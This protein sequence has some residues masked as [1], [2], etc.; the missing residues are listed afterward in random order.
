MKILSFGLLG[1]LT[2]MLMAA[3]VVEK[4][5]GSG[6]ASALLYTSPLTVAMWAVTAVCSAGYIIKWRRRLTW[7]ALLLH[8]A[9]IVILAG[10]AVTHF[11]GQQGKITISAG[12][13]TDSFTLAD[14]T[15]KQ[16]P[17][18]LRLRS[19]RIEC[20]PG[21]PT[22][23]DYV[24]ELTVDNGSGEE[25]ATVSM[26]N[27]LDVRGYRFYETAMGTDHTVLSVSHDP[28]GIGLTY[29]GYF[30]LLFA[31]VSFFFSRKT[32][33]F[34]LVKALGCVVL[35]TAASQSAAAGTT[36]LPQT[37]QRGLAK[38]FGRM[39]V[40]HN[41]RVCPVS[42]LA[43]DFCIKITGS[44]SY[45]GLSAEQVL[46][47]WIFYYPDWKNEPMVK[48]KPSVARQLGKEGK[49]VALS[50]FYSIDGFRL[51]EASTDRNVRDAIEKTALISSV[52]TG[53]ALKI[54]P[55]RL[56][57]GSAEWYSWTDDLPDETDADDR[58]FIMGS[59]EYFA[60]EIAHGRNISADS[61]TKRISEYQL[62]VLGS[63][64]GEESTAYR[65]EMLYNKYGRTLPIA[66]AALTAGLVTFIIFCRRVSKGGVLPGRIRIVF[67]AVSVIIFLCLTA[68]ISLRGIIAGQIPLGNG[69]E[70]ML[71]MAWVALLA[72]I[73][74]GRRVGILQP[75]SLIT[76]GL[77]LTVAMLSEKNPQVSHLMPVLQ[78]PLL[79][80]HVM[81]VMLSYALL[82][83][84]ALNSIAAFIAGAE[85]EASRRLAVLSRVMLY[86]ALF[87]LAAGI[88]TGAVWANQSWGRYWG[89]DPKE[90]WAL[91]T[92]IIYALPMHT[93]SFPALARPKTVHVYF[94]AAF[95]SVLITYFGVN[96]F[97]SGLHS[98]A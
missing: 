27:V 71:A 39:L 88:F 7:Q 72:G 67:F 11:A 26:N 36:E 53:S 47:G 2:L 1:V 96:F 48:V 56:D 59:M 83:F 66:I 16:L 81:E 77:A 50:D 79:S 13:N 42:T 76:A 89:W 87:L 58:R 90:T 28:W 17:F 4:I 69:Y 5:S 98:Y 43:R 8:G 80:V 10:A 14:G 35:L 33:F 12:E 21:T 73:V 32:R 52:C 60:R 24:S 54:Y 45:R 78:S 86:P 23:A 93:A 63:G 55:R 49:Y 70:T 94:L 75:A 34:A 30:L 41:G 38:D 91:I 84:M 44:D 68:I 97:L 25:D 46:T 64:Y 18:S 65:A 22:P 6:V 40:M 3:T 62:Q 15:V 85:S 57:D 9:F 19:V 31:M 61:V 74:L 95:L 29:G 37:L 82:L 51:D 92:M 20:Y